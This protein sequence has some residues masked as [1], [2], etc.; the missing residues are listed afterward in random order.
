MIK[1]L[2]QKAFLGG[3][4]FT[5]AIRKRNEN[6]CIFNSRFF[7]ADYVKP[8][9]NVEWYADPI[10]VDDKEKT[11]L[12]FEAV[13]NNKGRIEVAEVLEDG[14]VSE[15]TVIISGETH[16][17]Y[18]FVFRMNDDWYMIPESSERGEVCLFKAKDFPFHW[19]E[20]QVLLHEKAVDTTL[21]ETNESKYLLSFYLQDGSERVAPHCFRLT[22]ENGAFQLEELSWN[23]FNPLQVR[24]AGPIVQHDGNYYRPYQISRENVYGDAVGFAEVRITNSGLDESTVAVVHAEDISIPSGKWFDGLHTY[25][26]SKHFEAVDIRC[27]DFDLFKLCRRVFRK[28]KR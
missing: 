17:S 28:G 10:L 22:E 20:H 5:I 12:F 4:Y 19:K 23:D 26:C 7:V 16:Y 9:S 21:M 1:R 27:R 24:G 14:S 6:E 2:Y 25:T 3:R 15:P 8:A 13:S 11:Y 18:P